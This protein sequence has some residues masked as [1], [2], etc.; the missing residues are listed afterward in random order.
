MNIRVLVVDDEKDFVDQL[1]QRMEL[2]EYDVTTA[3]SGEAALEKLRSYN[4]DVIILDVLMTGMDGIETLQEAK[5]LKPLTEVIM[6][7]GHATVE[8]AIEGMKLGAFDYLKKPADTE[9]LIKK[10]DAAYSRKSEQDERIQQAR[11]DEIIASPRS[12]LR[13]E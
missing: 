1:S 13:D 2:R 3:Y 10:I 5:K 8:T 7:T 9:E 12:V 11:A 4:Y 6:L